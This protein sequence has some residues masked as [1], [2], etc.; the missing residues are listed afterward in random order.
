L[1]A[2]RGETFTDKPPGNSHRG[3]CLRDGADFG[4]G[5]MVVM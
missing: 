1:I 3:R 5:T 2:T 4:D